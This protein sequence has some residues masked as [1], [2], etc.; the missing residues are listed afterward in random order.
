MIGVK[1][2]LKAFYAAATHGPTGFTSDVHRSTFLETW[3]AWAFC[4]ERLA[5]R[6]GS[7]QSHQEKAGLLASQ[8]LVILNGKRPSAAS[9]ACFFF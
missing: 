5:E 3:A 6:G 1:L 9:P 2:A 7:Y 8:V 4:F